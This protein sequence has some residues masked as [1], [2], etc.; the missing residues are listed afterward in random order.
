M[1]SL[2]ED[3]VSFLTEALL[4]DGDGIDTFRDFVPEGPDS[5]VVLYEYSGDPVDPL[6]VIV[7]RSVQITTRSK[8]PY[9]ARTKALAIHDALNVETRIV[10]FTP[11]R[12]GQV[13]LRQSPFKIG[14]D[15]NDR[16]IYGFNVGIT[17]TKE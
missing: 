13:Y 16:T 7:H 5:I 11:T 6:D 10:D 9:L 14:K 2:L 3:I 15:E 1:A 12:W 4:V 17:T 8:D